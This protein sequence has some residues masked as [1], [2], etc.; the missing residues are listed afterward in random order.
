[1]T[2]C[3]ICGR[4]LTNPTSVAKGVGPICGARNY[5]G[6]IRA[7]H[8][9]YLGGWTEIEAWEHVNNP[10]YSCKLFIFPN[11][12][13]TQ[14][15]GRVVTHKHLQKLFH[16]SAIGGFCKKLQILVDGNTIGDKRECGRTGYLKRKTSSEQ[17]SGGILVGK[18]QIRINFE[19]P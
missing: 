8:G 3:S 15:G 5:S 14:E 12:E 6:R 13:E 10:C 17:P 18:R 9:S 2:K 19:T 16:L 11:T 4:P 1:M 7:R